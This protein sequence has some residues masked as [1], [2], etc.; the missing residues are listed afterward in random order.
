MCWTHCVQRAVLGMQRS[1]ATQVHARL[2]AK[3]RHRLQTGHP[4]LPPRPSVRKQSRYVPSR[5]L[6]IVR[7]RSSQIAFDCRVGAEAS[8]L[9]TLMDLGRGTLQE[10]RRR[11]SWTPSAQIRL[12]GHLLREVGAGEV[13]LAQLRSPPGESAPPSL[14]AKALLHAGNARKR[15]IDVIGLS[16]L[17]T[18]VHQRGMLQ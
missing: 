13:K 12:P 4:L 6:A 16:C 15:G 3:T 11:S 9:P 14:A 7:R 18:D 2:E 5:A 10:P 8:L 17:L 1:N